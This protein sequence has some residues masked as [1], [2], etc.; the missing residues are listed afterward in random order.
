M[1]ELGF[2]LRSAQPGGGGLPTL[3]ALPTIS[4]GE[5]SL[6]APSLTEVPDRSFW[7]CEV[8]E[9]PIPAGREQAAWEGAV[10]EGVSG[11]NMCACM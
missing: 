7:A 1:A 8:G 3:T 11:G 10:C 6:G 9:C 2:E 5:R 4:G